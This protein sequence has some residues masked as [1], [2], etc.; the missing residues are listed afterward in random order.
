[1]ELNLQERIRYS[2]NKMKFLTKA[3]GSSLNPRP[4]IVLI[5][6]SSIYIFFHQLNSSDK[7]MGRNKLQYVKNIQIY[8]IR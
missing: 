1:M 8:K 6:I 2:K 3:S 5:Q 4:M 7:F